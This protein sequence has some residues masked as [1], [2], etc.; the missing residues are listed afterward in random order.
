ML[1][2]ITVFWILILVGCGGI[3]ETSTKSDLCAWE[4]QLIG[5]WSANS[6]PY[7]I[8]EFYANGDYIFYNEYTD[9]GIDEWQG[10]WWCNEKG[11][12]ILKPML[13]DSQPTDEDPFK[14]NFYMTSEDEM[15]WQGESSIRLK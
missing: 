2:K 13:Q 3:Q 8:K 1:R 5:R 15:S 6:A 7:L 12:L 11:V 14:I 4:N 10:E 9:E